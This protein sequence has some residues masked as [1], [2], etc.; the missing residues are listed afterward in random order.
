MSLT[1]RNNENADSAPYF[2]NHDLPHV[3]LHPVILFIKVGLIIALCEGVIMA[4][5][6]LLA[7]NSKLE[8]ALDPF[9]LAIFGTICVYGFIVGPL[10]EMLGI[11]RKMESELDLFRSLIDKSNDAIFII[12]P[13]TAQILD[14]NYKA[15][16][17]LGYT[18]AEL[19]SMTI[20]DIGGYL[21]DGSWAEHVGKVRDKGHVFLQ[22][23]HKRKDGSTFSVEVNA[24]LIN[25]GRKDY[26]VAVARDITERVN[27]MNRLEESETKFRKIAEC[28][29]NGIVMMGP[30][31]EI[32]FWNSAAERI[33]GYSSDEAI[34]KDLH[35]LLVPARFRDAFQ[36][37][38]S[39][40]QKTG[41]GDV[42]D[43]TLKLAAIRKNGSEFSMEMS[44]AS[45][46]LNGKWHAV[47]IVRDLSEKKGMDADSVSHDEAAA[48]AVGLTAR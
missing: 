31:G 2:I 42:I 7:V 44:I 38:F 20:L 12:R 28:A 32:S 23:R 46:S 37:G 43:K 4:I 34:G 29:K 24:N 35:A 26:M 36:K 48:A 21:T 41:K 1:L 8:I 27:A 33:F 16:I 45:V 18:R 19:L 13:E 14:V 6:N 30:K 47:A 25:L 3:R 39:S 15:C 5:L 17:A 11:S 10:N 22:G 9:L 40:F